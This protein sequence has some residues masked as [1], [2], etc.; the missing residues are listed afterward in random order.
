[1]SLSVQ[2]AN[3]YVACSHYSLDD[4]RQAWRYWKAEGDVD[5]F[6]AF[7]RRCIAESSNGRIRQSI[8]ADRRMAA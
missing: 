8:A 2:E 1:M 4:L 3:A 7:I 5:A 6:E